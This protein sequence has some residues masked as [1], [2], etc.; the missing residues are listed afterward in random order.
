MIVAKAPLRISF[1]GGGT[2]FSSYF[3][4]QG[5]GQVLGTSIDRFVYVMLDA[6]PGFEK[7]RFKFTY[8]KVEEVEKVSDFRHPVVRS[9][10]EEFNIETPLNLATMASLPGRSGLGS[11]SAFT[12][13][14][15][16]AIFQHLQKEVSAERVAE[17]AVNLERIRIGEPGGLQDQ[18][19]SAIGG[20]RSYKFQKSGVTVSK[21]LLNYEKKKLIES[22]LALIATN[23]VRDSATYS[24][25][26]E[27]NMKN[28]KSLRELDSMRDICVEA[29]KEIECANTKDSFAILV[30]A[31]RESW[32]IKRDQIGDCSEE[33]LRII[34]K[35]ESVGAEAL[36]LC[37]AGG[38]GFVLI[39]TKPEKIESIL[40]YFPK[41]HIVRPNFYEK[42]VTTFEF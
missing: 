21:D 40:E 23:S 42:G 4:T 18:Y 37:G 22:G 15:Y 11:S 20:F 3:G 29:T 32:V 31:V 10:L 16:S 25:R 14:L 33:V 5:F 41:S 2:D 34:D 36:K 7:S 13:A 6:Q 35:A 24:A 39:L 27:A 1:L 12:V 19:H 30:N 9:L 28:K 38:A 17:M 26:H 8:R